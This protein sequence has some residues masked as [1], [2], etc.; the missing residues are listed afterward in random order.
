MHHAIR[1]QWLRLKVAK[2]TF[3]L[4]LWIQNFFTS[5]FLPFHIYTWLFNFFFT[6]LWLIAPDL[7]PIKQYK[8][9]KWYTWISQGNKSRVPE[10]TV[11]LVTALFLVI[12][13]HGKWGTVDDSIWVRAGTIWIFQLSVFFMMHKTAGIV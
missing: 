1:N 13:I 8:V 4:S 3:N 2:V 10:I 12:S 5:N 7:N 9:M 6:H 11:P